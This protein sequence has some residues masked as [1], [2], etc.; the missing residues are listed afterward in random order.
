[1]TNEVKRFCKAV[2]EGWFTDGDK[3]V[4]KV[5][6]KWNNVFGEVWVNSAKQAFFAC[7]ILGASKDFYGGQ[8]HHK[9]N[10]QDARK[11]VETLV[12]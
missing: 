5:A 11:Y 2:L 7:A 12:L 3:E 4:E 8:H 10:L 1:M 6:N 9:A